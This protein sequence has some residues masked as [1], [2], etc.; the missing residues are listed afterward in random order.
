MDIS[1]KSAND[2]IRSKT[3][4]KIKSSKNL[5]EDEECNHVEQTDEKL[6]VIP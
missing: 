3:P 1:P 5:F 2:K 4:A 6:S